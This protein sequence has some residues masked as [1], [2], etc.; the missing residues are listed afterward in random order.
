VCAEEAEEAVA[1]KDAPEGVQKAL[2]DHREGVAPDK[3][4]REVEDGFVFYEAEFAEGDVEY[5]VK[6]DEEGR[7][8]E[9]EEELPLSLLPPEARNSILSAY[10]NAEIEEIERKTVI[11]YE[12][13]LKNEAKEFEVR[14]LEN[15]FLL[16]EEVEEAEE[17]EANEKEEQ[18]EKGDITWEELPQS[19]RKAIEA[20]KEGV[21][22]VGIECEKVKGRVFYEAEY[23]EADG[24]QHEIRVD[25]TGQIVEIEDEIP[26]SQ[27]P[28]AILKKVESLHPGVT[29]EEVE[30]KQS[31][32]YVVEIEEGDKETEV[33]VL[34][35]GLIL[36]VEE[37]D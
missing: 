5:D 31:T 7:I 8:V 27:V 36:G 9:I 11:H 19:V 4:V 13:E 12:L 16:G 15:G 20:H 24:V 17:E 23:E 1:L 10:P 22:P 26:A 21:R 33:K 32:F 28:A 30:L 6:T 18:E 29:I 14:I 25:E 34:A 2:A 3:L 37:D 35:N